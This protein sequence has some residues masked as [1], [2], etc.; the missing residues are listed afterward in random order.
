MTEVIPDKEVARLAALRSYNIL[1]SAPEPAYDEI[2]ELAAQ[3][4]QCPAA[5][6][7][8]I[9][10][11]H[12]WSKSRYGVP[13]RRGPIPRELTV[14]STAM[15]GS[16]LLVVPDLTKNQRFAQLPSVVR[17]PYL[18]FYCGMP[19]INTEGHA[20]GTL[21]VLDFR[22]HDDITFEQQEALRRLS[23]QV[24]TQMEL[25][26]SLLALDQAR[27]EIEV[28]RERSERLL[29]N[30]LPPAVAE[31]LKDRNHVTPRFYDAATIL[32]ADFEGFTKLAERM[33]P[34]E[35]VEQLDEYFSAFDEIAERHG[36]E[37]LKTIGDAYMCVGGLP[38]ANRTHPVDACLAA[39]EMQQFIAGTNRGREMLHLS[40][41]DVRVGLHTGPVIAGVVGRRKFIYDVWGDAVNV[42]ARME[43]AGAAGKINV[44]E[45]VYQ[46][47]KALFD[48]EPRGNLQV[49]NKG[50]LDMF[51]LVQIKPGLARDNEGC[52]PNDAF[53]A[54]CERLFPGYARSA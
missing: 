37:M 31:E 16:D 4:C 39:L 3:V 22:P 11:K 50:Q 51:F 30:M 8:V 1:G 13:P 46:R 33:E 5:G 27:Q 9:D 32:F 35:L 20:L 28:Q 42:A 25:R 41:W 10:D 43:T 53:A 34:K 40:R 47:A 15:C 7:N 26:R 54:E 29:R 49:K 36:L 24:V 2:T 45:A 19:L 14:C 18:R 17:E 44:S 52:M 12:V 48:F 38:E 6:I 21:C 23:R